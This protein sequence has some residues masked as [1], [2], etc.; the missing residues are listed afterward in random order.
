MHL[1]AADKIA[2][3]EEKGV[4]VVS[5]GGYG[6]AVSC[7]ITAE[8]EAEGM[9]REVVHRVQTLRRNAG[10]D[11]AD[12]IVLYYEADAFI[13]QSLSSF[14][15]YI[16]QETLARSIEDALPDDVDLKEE[17]KVSGYKLVLGVKK[18]A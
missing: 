14:A 1:D 2:G 6:V 7:Y 8:L 13:M 9:A 16:M 18:V 15:D 17:F 12:H 10:Y 3:K 4:S 5:E 11:I